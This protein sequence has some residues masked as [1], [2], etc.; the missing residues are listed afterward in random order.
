MQR[1]IDG[2]FFQ[3]ALDL[4]HHASAISRI[5]WPPGGRNKE[6][7]KRAQRRGQFLR[8]LLELQSGHALQNRALRDHFEHFDE[9]LDEWAESS[10]N[11]NIVRQLFGPRTAIGG[12]AIQDSDIIH[13]FDP[14]TNIFG[15]RGEH[16]N[17]QE[18]ATGIDDIY[19]RIKT[20][21][22]EID[23]NK[24]INTRYAYVDSP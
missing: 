10:K 1:K 3:Y 14:D 22:G 7:K 12:D 19:Q 21:I 17:I 8:D 13:H 5:F 15:F 23:A 11:R 16:Y 24:R 2:D 18:L 4:I 6:S 20:K 9:R